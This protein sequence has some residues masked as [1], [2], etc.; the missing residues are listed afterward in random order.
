MEVTDTVELGTRL[1]LDW[2]E[3]TPTLFYAKHKDLLTTVHDPRVNLSYSQNVGDATGYGFELDAN[4]FVT[5]YLT[6]FCNPS[7]TVLTYDDDL[8]YQGATLDARG[9]QVVDAPRWMVKTGLILTHEGFEIVPS[10]RYLGDRYGDVQHEEKIGE[11]VVAD[12][13]IGYTLKDVWGAKALKTALEL[14]NLFDKRYVSVINASDD[15]RGGAASY[16]AGA[17]FTAVFKVALDL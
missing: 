14:N 6:I 17:P 15:N 9:A 10:L 5:D 12:L 2:A 11:Y 4:V 7:Y 8:T 1:R 13:K 3:I 16:Y